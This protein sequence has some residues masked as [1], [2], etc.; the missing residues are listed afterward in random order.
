MDC[1]P[2]RVRICS[3][4]IPKL[5]MKRQ[6]GKSFTNVNAK[7]IRSPPLDGINC[8]LKNVP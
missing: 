6:T 2:H 3:G 8:V 4:K 1:N 5:V 7:L